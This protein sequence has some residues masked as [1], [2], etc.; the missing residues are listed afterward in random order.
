MLR[1]TLRDGVFGQ[2]R[3]FSE[4]VPQSYLLARYISV[5]PSFAHFADRG[6]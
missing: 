2:Q 5:S 1:G 3:V 4:Q 6:R